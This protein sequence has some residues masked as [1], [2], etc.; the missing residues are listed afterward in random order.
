MNDHFKATPIKRTSLI[1]GKEQTIVIPMTGAEFNEAWYAYK[2]T[3][4]LLQ[5]AF[6]NLSPDHR[7]FIKTGITPQEWNETFNRDIDEEEDS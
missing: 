6:P 4:L 7:E 1:S 5:E 2:H 3:G